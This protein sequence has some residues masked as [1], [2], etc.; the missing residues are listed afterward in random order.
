MSLYKF[1]M[2]TQ[3]Y[4]TRGKIPLCSIIL[5]CC[6]SPAVIIVSKEE[7]EKQDKSRNPKP[8]VGQRV[9]ILMSHC[10]ACL[11]QM[12]LLAPN[13]PISCWSRGQTLRLAKRIPSVFY[14][15]SLVQKIWCHTWWYA[16]KRSGASCLTLL[17]AR[18]SGVGPCWHQTLDHSSS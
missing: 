6:A 7:C 13:A 15:A 17:L 11:L 3:L 8:V 10:N 18:L 14:P 9:M 2:G 16:S 12:S 4:I 5:V 1:H